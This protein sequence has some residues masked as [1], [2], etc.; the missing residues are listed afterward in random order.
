MRRSNTPAFAVFVFQAVLLSSGL[1]TVVGCVSATRM[2]AVT[3]SLVSAPA[4]PTAGVPCAST[5]ASVPAMATVTLS[6]ETAPAMMVGG[7]P[8]APS[9]ASALS[10]DLWVRRVTS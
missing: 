8:P 5:P 1:R 4:T 7:R 2:A 3:L 10:G 6:M 9:R